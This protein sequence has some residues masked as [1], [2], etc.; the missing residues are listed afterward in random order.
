MENRFDAKLLKLF[1]NKSLNSFLKY[2]LRYKGWMVG[3][4]ILSTI[5]SL[6]SAVPAWLSK[7]LID[8]VL[9]SKMPKL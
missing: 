5:T 7:Y 3:V 8:D 9:V 4:I 1:H 6:A 2:S